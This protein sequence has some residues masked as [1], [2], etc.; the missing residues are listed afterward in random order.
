MEKEKTIGMNIKFPNDLNELLLDKVA[1][2]RKRG[3]KTT[4]E[5]LIINL[6][7][8]HRKELL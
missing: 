4:K 3:K 8:K 1:T 2:E 6:I 7:K 5:K